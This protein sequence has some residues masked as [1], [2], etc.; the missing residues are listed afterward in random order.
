MYAGIISV[1]TYGD[2]QLRFDANALVVERHNC[3]R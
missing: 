2:W 3:F 1:G